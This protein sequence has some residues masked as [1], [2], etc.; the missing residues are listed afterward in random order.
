VMLPDIS[1]RAVAEAILGIHRGVR[2]L[3]MSGYTGA[4]LD[5][6]GG[7]PS[8]ATFLSKPF[9]LKTLLRKTREVL[10]GRPAAHSSS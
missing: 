3:Y 9:T 10:D 4:A 1:G 5:S 2:I 6:A 8:G 7:L